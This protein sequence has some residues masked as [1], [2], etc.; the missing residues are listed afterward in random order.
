MSKPLAEEFSFIAARLKELEKE[1]FP[2]PEPATP[3]LPQLGAA[4]GISSQMPSEDDEAELFAYAYG[5][6]G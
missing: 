6:M 3:P 4:H 2:Q 1:R 5:Y